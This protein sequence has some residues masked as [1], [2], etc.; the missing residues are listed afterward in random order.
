MS[1]ALVDSLICFEMPFFAVAHQYA[2]QASDYIDNSISFQARLPFL[3]ALRD[4]FGLKDV[5]QDT[6]DT[7]RGRGISYQAYEPAEGGLHYGAGRQKRIRAGLRYSKGGKSKYWIP[8]PGDEA[9]TRGD[10]GPIATIKRRVDERL[11]AREGFA[12]L[13][14][15]Q[16]AR[17]VHEDPNETRNGH[18]VEWRGLSTGL[19]ADSDSDASDAPSLEFDSVEE[20]DNAMY[21]RARRIGYAGFPNVDVSKE[22]ARWRQWEEEERILAGRSSRKAGP[23]RS[24]GDAGGS[25]SSGS[26]GKG[27]ASQPKRPVYGACEPNSTINARSPLTE[28]I[29]ADMV[30]HLAGSTASSR[31]P[32]HNPTGEGEWLIEGNDD[33]R[34]NGDPSSAA[35]KKV[36]SKQPK[37]SSLRPSLPK[38]RSS[39]KS[40]F[41]LGHEDSSEDD[42]PPAPRLPS[43]ARDIVVEDAEAVDKARARER[44][45]G[46]PQSHI[47]S[48][49]Y[50]HHNN[51]STQRKGE[52]FKPGALK[53]RSKDSKDLEPE[54]PKAPSRKSSAGNP[55]PEAS[56]SEPH[57]AEEMDQEQVANTDEVER[58]YSPDLPGERRISEAVSQEE[59]PG[60]DPVQQIERIEDI[61]TRPTPPTSRT[62]TSSNTGVNHSSHFPPLDDHENP[63]A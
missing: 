42:D 28:T 20:D 41:A 6:K 16:A 9:L 33:R 37:I 13:L 59:M 4:A 46:E 10:R 26:K 29:G 8:R 21:E 30:S 38:R 60:G 35:S 54:A 49:V 43:D 58:V 45:S 7:F 11:A 32:S 23:S 40:P 55:P 12:P 17:V 14:P 61:I 50:V 19:F 22:E 31:A 56:Y 18:H 34:A 51:P 36:K 52:A 2:F 47:P 63:W 3:Y 62:N 5:W 57:R 48:R 24:N 27:K 15:K 53:A 39:R 1:L 44:R 25:S